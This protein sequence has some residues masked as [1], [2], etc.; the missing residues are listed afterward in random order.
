MANYNAALT[1]RGQGDSTTTINPANPSGTVGPGNAL[2]YGSGSN[3]VET[4]ATGGSITP[5]GPYIAG[6]TSDLIIGTVPPGKAGIP[7]IRTTIQ[8]PTQLKCGTASIAG[9]R[10]MADN[11][12]PATASQTALADPSTPA[13]DQHADAGKSLSPQHE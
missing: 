11:W 9:S 12:I 4:S 8:N 6:G 5:A 13:A 7:Q 2:Q 1:T 10:N 3:A